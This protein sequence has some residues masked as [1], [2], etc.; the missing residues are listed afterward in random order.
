M[1]TEITTRKLSAPTPQVARSLSQD[2][3]EEHRGQIAFEV[4]VVLDGYWDKRPSDAVKAGIL[5]DWA[6]TL[7]DWTQEQ[8]L[9]GLRKWRDDNPSKK[10]NP[11]HVLGILKTL[12]GKAEAKRAA[13]SAPAREPEP[14]LTAEER[15][16]SRKRVADLVANAGFAKRING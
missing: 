1:G 6:D 15:E 4:E 3:L 16:A 11:S 9:Y 5:A 2:E 14:H 10:P 12:R 7:E 8:I 13:I